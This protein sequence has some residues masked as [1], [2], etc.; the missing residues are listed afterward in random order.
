M[1]SF[2]VSDWEALKYRHPSSPFVTKAGS[3]FLTS[4]TRISPQ[5]SLITAPAS[6]DPNCSCWERSLCSEFLEQ[7]QKMWPRGRIPGT[8]KGEFL[9]HRTR[10]GSVA[11]SLPT[12]LSF[13]GFVPALVL[14]ICG[15]DGS[16]VPP[17]G[18]GWAASP[19][20]SQLRCPKPAPKM[21]VSAVPA[22]PAD[23]SQREI[24]EPSPEC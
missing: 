7:G 20:G 16:R 21:R 12:K 1:N 9:A 11:I 18:S 15:A 19:G 24:T 17:P 6:W 2:P 3:S 13:C 10:V 4:E 14:G 5:I 22:L 8:P 23:G